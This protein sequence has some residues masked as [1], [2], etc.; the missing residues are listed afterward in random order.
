MMENP[1]DWEI[2]RT[3]EDLEV[4][5]KFRNEAQG[6]LLDLVE[7]LAGIPRWKLRVRRRIYRRMKVL[8][9][10]SYIQGV[11]INDLSRKL[12]ETKKK[13]D[14]LEYVRDEK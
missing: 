4:C 6:E 11:L 10:D 14:A 3:V 13:S 1:Y 12:E 5:R 9:F 8:A 2:K 7:K